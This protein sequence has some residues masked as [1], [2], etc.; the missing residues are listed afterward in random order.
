MTDLVRWLSFRLGSRVQSSSTPIGRSSRDRNSSRPS[1]KA[2]DFGRLPLSSQQRPSNP[3]QP[4]SALS[5]TAPALY[6]PDRPTDRTYA[7]APKLSIHLVAYEASPSYILRCPPSPS[8]PSSPPRPS[9]S[10]LGPRPSSSSPSRR[11]SSSTPLPLPMASSS[12]L[13]LQPILPEWNRESLLEYGRVHADEK[14]AFYWH[15]W[16]LALKLEY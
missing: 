1:L 7:S 10:S 13:R 9:P 8:S 11:D 2:D 3:S 4:T 16:A 5:L 6:P 14:D 12:L 15:H